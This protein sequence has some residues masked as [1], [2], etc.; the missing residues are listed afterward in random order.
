MAAISEA[1][2]LLDR[3]RVPLLPL[4]RGRLIDLTGFRG[5]FFSLPLQSQAR[6]YILPG[7]HFARRNLNRKPLHPHTHTH[8]HARARA[9]FLFL[10]EISR[11]S[12]S[13]DVTS[14]TGIMKVGSI[15]K[16]T[17]NEIIYID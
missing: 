1:L 9:L 8:T 6:Y 15:K 7:T 2:N 4:Q 14:N 16:V 3:I 13:A 10:A 17:S 5:V 12:Y 11:N